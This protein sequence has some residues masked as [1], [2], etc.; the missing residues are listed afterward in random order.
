MSSP[1]RVARHQTA[2]NQATLVPPFVVALGASLLLLACSGGS[3]KTAA[4]TLPGG[5]PYGRVVP[6]R[7]V[8]VCDDNYPPYSFLD[9]EGRPEGIVPDQWKAWSAITGVPAD[10]RPMPWSRAIATFE[11]GGADVLDTV[12]ETPPRERI[13]DFTRAYATLSVPVFIH[14]GISGIS[15]LSD[16]RGFRIA[17]KDGDAAIDQLKAGGASDIV[18]YPSYEAIIRDAAAQN[19]KVFTIDKPPALYFLYKYGIEKDFR[20]AFELSGGQFHRA[21]LKGHPSTLALVE[22]GFEAIPARTIASIDERWM[23]HRID[24]WV[25]FKLI[26]SIGSVVLLA[27]ILLL[28]LAWTLRRRVALATAD[29]RDKVLQLEMSES[30]TKAALAD[31]NVLLKEV[32]H[33]VKNNMQVMSSLIELATYDLHDEADRHLFR[34]TQERIRAMAQLHELLYA[35]DDLSSIDAGEYI[36]AVVAELAYG[37][38][39]PEIESATCHGK[40]D[41]DHAVPLGLVANELVL[42]AIKY[43]YAD[44]RHGSI[45]V[46]FAKVGQVF[47]LEVRDEGGGFPPGLDPFTCQSMGLTLV[48][49]LAGQLKASLGFEGPP[50]LVATLGFE[51]A[52]GIEVAP[53]PH[54]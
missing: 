23:G 8:V 51:V 49:S 45:R 12:F 42:N 33:R 22:L 1:R 4:F 24:E 16:L 20:I 5:S 25:D 47:T 39:Y 21:V 32:H 34:E 37:H 31:K 43:A 6:D 53:A 46:T 44:G 17:A 19:V 9:P 54:E 15:R 11:A 48:R 40:L 50:G 52:P 35:S 28:V 18:T 27:F 38:G 41:I 26:A 29:L 10:V 14:R 13:Y 30:R 2:K 36:D 3:S 7:L